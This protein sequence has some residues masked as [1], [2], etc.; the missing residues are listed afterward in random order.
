LTGNYIISAL[1]NDFGVSSLVQGGPRA[2]ATTLWW[3]M[4]AIYLLYVGI[5]LGKKYHSEKLLGLI[6]LGI[7]LIKVILYDIANMEMQNKI[8][9]LMLVGGA[10]LLFSYYVRS[11]NLLEKQPTESE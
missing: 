1:M 6:L 4:I 11:K 2:I 5:K 8:I 10:M 9:I 7:T 3:T